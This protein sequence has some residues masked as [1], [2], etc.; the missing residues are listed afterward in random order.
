VFIGFHVAPASPLLKMPPPVVPEYNTAWLA[1]SIFTSRTSSVVRPEDEPAHD[2]P[3]FVD[4]KTPPVVPAYK[5]VGT[6]GSTTIA[7]TLL[8]VIPVPRLVHD[9]P[10]SVVVK[11][12][13]LVAA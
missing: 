8:L 12:P 6:A 5:V 2:V 4:L 13:A 10:A 3:P 7:L 1:G 11:M 9:E